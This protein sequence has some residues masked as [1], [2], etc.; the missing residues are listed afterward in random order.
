M[1][2]AVIGVG[3]IGAVLSGVLAEKGNFI[4]AIDINKEFID[5]WFFGGKNSNETFILL[6]ETQLI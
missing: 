1:K 3:Y 2:I 4:T 6:T 5:S